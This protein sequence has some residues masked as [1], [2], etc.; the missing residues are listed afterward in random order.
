[1]ST[2]LTSKAGDP[3]GGH[4]R[5]YVESVLAQLDRLPSLSPVAARLLALTTAPDSSARD[6]VEVIQ[7]DAPMTSALLRLVNRADRGGPRD[8]TTVDRAVTLLGFQTVRK[9]ALAVKVFQAFNDPGADAAALERR[10]GMWLHNIAVACLAESLAERITHAGGHT[11]GEAFLCGLLH[12]I[13]KIALDASF[14][15]S[16]TR[17]IDRLV[18]RRMDISDAERDVFGLDHT[19][20][21]KRIA[22]RWQLPPCVVECAWLH[23]QNPDDLPSNVSN[24]QL[25]ALIHLADSLVRRHGIGFSG[26][27]AIADTH[28]AAQSLGISDA[29]LGEAV[30]Q[31]SQRMAPL[32]EAVGLGDASRTMSIDALLEA[33]HQ[34]GELC[35]TLTERNQ[36]LELRS[37]LFDALHTFTRTA[38]AQASLGEVCGHAAKTLLGVFLADA[39]LVIVADRDD[40]CVYVG[41]A[42]RNETKPSAT[43]LEHAGHPEVVRYLTQ[44]IARRSLV[45][46]SPPTAFEQ[47][48]QRFHTASDRH[49]VR[50]LTLPAPDGSAGC[51]L[52]SMEDS[53]YHSW[54]NALEDIMSLAGTIG[55]A[56]A[57]TRA[58]IGAEHMTEELVDLNRR[59]RNA[60]AEHLRTRSVAMIA[61]MADGAAHELNNPLSVI[62]G[63]AQLAMAAA[64]D[65]EVKRCLEIIQEQ[66][67]RAA[68]IALDLMAFA[69]PEPPMPQQRPLRELLE[70]FCQ[71]WQ[72]RFSL[73]TEQLT[74]T[75]AHPETTIFVDPVHLKEILTAI[76]SNAVASGERER[77][78]VEINS[79]SRPSDEAVR[80][81]VRDNGVGM[82][83][84]VLEHALDPFYSHRPAGRGRGLG[85]SKAYRLTEINGGKLWLESTSGVG[86]TVTIELPP[87]AP[88]T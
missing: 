11:A 6:L 58:R 35:A 52:I 10:R 47:L 8:V 38:S 61:E 85:L 48:W 66:T 37:R 24:P 45:L 22:G 88:A 17:V 26:T 14:P 87:R 32:V 31:L 41:S 16:Y 20:A 80:I 13:G 57:G 82:T 43:I 18:Q 78:H 65:P 50:L 74:V 19:I 68:N 73:A 60:Q 70:P 51:A 15:K 33:N 56:L 21:G 62:S 30:K 7:S 49:P 72:E 39:S 12:D 54:H 76:V 1:M 40:H 2:S 4:S 83:G 34:L 86:T 23:H 3:H 79:P 42:A 46:E 25:V 63:R 44:E 36:Y 29:A 77:I 69:K 28:T 55:R 53:S 67:V 59:L 9:L 64:N 5:G 71:H 27:S 81:V 75:L 84:E